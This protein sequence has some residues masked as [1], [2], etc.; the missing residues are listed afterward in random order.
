MNDPHLEFPTASGLTS[1]NVFVLTSVE[2]KDIGP[3]QET[4]TPPTEPE[5]CGERTDCATR[6]HM[7]PHSPKS[8]LKSSAQT[9]GTIQSLYLEQLIRGST[10][11][12][13]D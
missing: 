9:P 11:S 1:T 7:L 8:R 2:D 3:L 12:L 6:R 4:G 10:W 5:F 13:N